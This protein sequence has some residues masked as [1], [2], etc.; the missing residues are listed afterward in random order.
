[1]GD[2]HGVQVEIPTVATSGP[3]QFSGV[4]FGPEPPDQIAPGSSR[5]P[6]VSLQHG[7]GDNDST[8]CALS[9]AAK[10]LAG[11]GYITE[12]HQAPKPPNESLEPQT[13]NG[14]RATASAVEFMRSPQ[15]PY[16]AI[17]DTERIG[18]GGSSM[19]SIVVSYIQGNPPPSD[20]ISAQAGLDL[21]D[22]DVDTII[23]YDNLR[24][25]LRGDPG[26][27][28]SECVGETEFE[29][30]PRVPALG[31]A[32]DEL[33]P[34]QVGSPLDPKTKQPGWSWWR[35]SG[36][37]SMSLVMRG[38]G[39]T[40]FTQTGD[41]EQRI[42][43]A[44][45]TRLWFDRWLKDSP[46]LE[47]DLLAPTVNGEP[48]V[49][50]LSQQFSSAACLGDRV[51]SGDLVSWFA[52][53]SPAPSGSDPDSCDSTIDTPAGR[54]RI[55]SLRLSAARRWVRAGG[56]RTVRLRIR[57]SGTIAADR[58]R[59]TLSSSN[60]KVRVPGRITVNRI[61]PGGAATVSFRVRVNRRAAGR[62]VL[63]ARTAG[64]GARLVLRIR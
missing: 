35:E 3:G 37:P 54:P 42:K 64:V 57:N 24:R 46:E 22:L 48:T 58:L 56:V 26:G 30:I 4:V 52:D 55:S 29:V 20:A 38:F 45:Y 15:N 31:F 41:E 60:R 6:V 1:M 5:L 44:H 51:D 23:A 63:R 40:D 19:G 14:I 32:M 59:I 2:M 49:D 43:L 47:S 61:A 33:C 11:H 21:S 50:I 62:V 36:I 9:W 8:I 34:Q 27:A 17:T 39:H 53:G 18:A 16:A 25:W 12:I 10:Y 7:A 28:R 13:I